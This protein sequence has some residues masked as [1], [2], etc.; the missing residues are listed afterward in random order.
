M[1]AKRQLYVIYR[2]GV[3]LA[4]VMRGISD[5]RGLTVAYDVTFKHDI[6]GALSTATILKKDAFKTEEEASKALFM[7]N[8]KKT[9]AEQNQETQKALMD[10]SR[11]QMSAGI[12]RLSGFR[13]RYD[14]DRHRP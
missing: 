7:R 10:I 1:N 8:L 2:D 9:R 6:P 11:K 12:R 14:P 5:N 3:H 13:H 4:E